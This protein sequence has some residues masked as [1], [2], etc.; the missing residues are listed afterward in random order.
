MSDSSTSLPTKLVNCGPAFTPKLT[1]ASALVIPKT[2][3]AAIKN[4]FFICLIFVLK[5]VLNNLF[6]TSFKVSGRC[7]TNAVPKEKEMLKFNTKKA[8]RFYRQDGFS[9]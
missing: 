4:I 9:L 6:I 8:V 2:A 1:C 3:K 5:E 7:F